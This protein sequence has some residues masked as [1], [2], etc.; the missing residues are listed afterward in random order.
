MWPFNKKPIISLEEPWEHS[1]LVVTSLLKTSFLL[2]EAHAK[3]CEI[4]GE[5]SVSGMIKNSF[6]IFTECRGIKIITYTMWLDG[7]S[8]DVLDFVS[9]SFG[10]H[11]PE[12]RHWSLEGE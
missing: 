3:A 4:F 11:K 9:V 6:F 1:A 12:V 7:N 8:G 10:G 2:G 5:G